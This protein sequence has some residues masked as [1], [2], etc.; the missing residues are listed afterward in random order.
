MLFTLQVVH[1]AFLSPPPL[2]GL[3]AVYDVHLR[4]IGKRVVDFILVLI[5]LFCQVLRMR[6]YEQISIENRFLYNGV[7]LA[8]NF[9]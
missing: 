3:G 4:L 2:E 1:F 6:R 8:Q 7:S 9:R 5:E